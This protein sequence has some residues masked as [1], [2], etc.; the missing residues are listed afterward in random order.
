MEP[1]QFLVC[2]LRDDICSGCLAEDV[3]VELIQCDGCN[4]WV[5]HN[6]FD[7]PL[8][9]KSWRC[10]A[11]VSHKAEGGARPVCALCPYRGSAAL[12]R[13]DHGHFAHMAC[14]LY[15]PQ[16]HYNFNTGTF[17]PLCRLPNA[18]LQ[19]QECKF[20]H[21]SGGSVV[22]CANIEENDRPCDV[23]F[24]PLC[25][26]LQRDAAHQHQHGHVEEHT[27]EIKMVAL[28]DDQDDV[29]NDYVG[30]AFCKQHGNPAIATTTSTTKTTTSEQ[31]ISQKSHTAALLV[32]SN[33]P[34]LPSHRKRKGNIISG[35]IW[36]FGQPQKERSHKLARTQINHNPST[37]VVKASSSDHVTRSKSTSSQAQKESSQSRISTSGLSAL[38][39]ASEHSVL[40]NSMSGESFPSDSFVNLNKSLSLLLPAPLSSLSA[41]RVCEPTKHSQQQLPMDISMPTITTTTTTTVQKCVIAPE[42][43][44]TLAQLRLEL[45]ESEQKHQQQQLL[46]QKQQTAWQHQWELQ[47]VKFDGAKKTLEDQLAQLPQNQLTSIVNSESQ[48]LQ[49]PQQLSTQVNTDKE[50]TAKIQTTRTVDDTTRWEKRYHSLKQNFDNLNKEHA[51]LLSNVQTDVGELQ[52]LRQH[53]NTL[54]NENMVLKSQV[55]PQISSDASSHHHQATNQAGDTPSP[56]HQRNI[57][58][59]N[60]EML[61][62]ESITKLMYD[63][64]RKHHRQIT[65]KEHELRI[66]REQ[67]GNLQT[68][69]APSGSQQIQQEKSSEI[70]KKNG[71]IINN[72]RD[73]ASKE[74]D[75]GVARFKIASSEISCLREEVNQRTLQVSRLQ[76]DLKHARQTVVDLKVEVT[77]IKGLQSS[78]ERRSKDD[79]VQAETLRVELWKLKARTKEMTEAS[80]SANETNNNLKQEVARLQIICTQVSESLKSEQV[81]LLQTLS[82]KNKLQADNSNMKAEVQRLSDENNTLQGAMNQQRELHVKEIDSKNALLMKH[83]QTA[84]QQLQQSENTMLQVQVKAD[85]LENCV[86]QLSTEL[87]QTMRQLKVA[88]GKLE[89]ANGDMHMRTQVFSNVAQTQGTLTQ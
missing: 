81:N 50:T 6:C 35:C 53:V 8:K 87:L 43:N 34:P 1:T 31:Q 82:D 26:I 48:Q 37:H 64:A 60:N 62:V 63:Q 15:Q 12:I 55:S 46:R 73:L 66:A 20:C 17:L 21:E 36:K 70:E 40:D 89:K 67:L 51:S 65:L 84:Q 86:N 30:V 71:D 33:F 69:Q 75:A 39:M 54:V 61:S 28:Y 2:P 56:K 41:L 47:R 7:I 19:G 45:Q 38:V 42:Q 16:L 10:V 77:A 14:I 85:Q 52:K 76:Q 22:Q 23:H 13:D 57:N 49:Q 68:Q 4:L 11:C 72:Q 27:H 29:P 5:H 88:Y 83:D 59:N 79:A 25:S 3:D 44:D 9:T 78:A 58:N 18:V 80:V 24:H 74:P 32:R